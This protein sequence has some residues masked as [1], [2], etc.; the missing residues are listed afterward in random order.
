MAPFFYAWI[1]IPICNNDTPVRAAATWC[2]N[3]SQEIMKPVPFA[4]GR[5]S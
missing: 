2:L 5:M 1:P 4:A 3:T